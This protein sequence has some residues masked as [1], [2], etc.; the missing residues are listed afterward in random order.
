MLHTWLLWSLSNRDGN[1]NNFVRATILHVHFVVYF[2]A[3][4]ARIEHEIQPKREHSG[5]E[6]G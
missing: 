6:V 2:F 1:L 5:N 4:T 3:V